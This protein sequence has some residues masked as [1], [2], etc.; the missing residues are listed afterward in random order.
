MDPLDQMATEKSG[1]HGIVYVLSNPAMPG[2]L[3]IGSTGRADVQERLRTLYST[4][5]P[6]PFQCEIARMVSAY[7]AVE[8]V[9]HTAFDPSRVNPR[10]EFFEVSLGQVE[11]V[12][13]LVDGDDVT[14]A[15]A[16]QGEAAVDES[17]RVAATRL[18]RR[19]RP[20]MNFARMGIAVGEQVTC[21]ETGDV[22][23]VVGETRVRFQGE[24][25]SL[26][27]A[28]QLAHGLAPGS[29]PSPFWSYE[30]RPLI[31]IYHETHPVAD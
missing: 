31:Q 21:I 22:A 25:M 7:Q 20:A 12:L 14:P 29:Q 15:I 17:S 2:M 13:S 26:T 30:G 28:T 3:K 10:R 9:L 24:V 18:V 19:K 8:G 4:G 1:D 11:A 27:R 5:V 23:D 16:D 6:V